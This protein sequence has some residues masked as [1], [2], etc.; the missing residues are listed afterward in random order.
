M[1]HN[2]KEAFDLGRTTAAPSIPTPTGG[3]AVFVPQNTQRIDIP[4]LEMPLPRIRQ[5]VQ[6][7]DLDSFIDYVNRFKA[8]GPTRIFAEPGFVAGGASSIKAI[9]DYHVPGTPD[10]L[11]HTASYM[12][13]HSTEWDIWRG[14]CGG[15]IKQFDFCEFIE[16]NRKDI[17]EP[18][19]A[20]LLDIVRTFKVA[21]KVEY[22]SVTYTSD[23][24]AFLNYSD[25]VEQQGKSGALPEI[26][27]IGIP[28]FFRGERFAVHVF[29]RFKQGNG[30]VNF[31]LKLDRADV[32]E[33]EAF[34]GL[35]SKVEE[36][37]GIKP[38]LGKV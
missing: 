3:L 17:E 34:K 30:A 2:F 37:T 22:D 27:K 7:H 6:L 14:I 28:V 24:S 10:R 36:Q 13:R 23:G 29:V 12:P 33:D 5:S 35:L 18:L 31:S 16:E 8:D 20:Q 15:V 26:M 32:I 1:D 11:A 21:R 4:P 38:Y 19:A 9:F 25:K